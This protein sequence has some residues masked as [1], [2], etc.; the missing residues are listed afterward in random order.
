MCALTVFNPFPNDKSLGL[1]KLKA[2]ADDKVN[3]AHINSS[4]F[5]RVEN[6]VGNRENAGYQYFL[7]FPQY[8]QWA[9]LSGLFKSPDY[10]VKS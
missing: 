6:I 1:T 8:F 4:V 7:L 9:S 2:F 5:N 10:V 3:A